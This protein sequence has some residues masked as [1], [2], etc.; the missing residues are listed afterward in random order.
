MNRTPLVLAVSFPLLG[1]IRNFHPLATCAA[2]RTQKEK[3]AFLRPFPIFT[4]PHKQP[5]QKH[6][7]CYIYM[8]GTLTNSKFF[9][10]LT[11]CRLVLNNIICDFYC[12]LLD[13]IFHILPLQLLLLQCMQRILLVCL[14]ISAFRLRS[15]IFPYASILKTFPHFV[16]FRS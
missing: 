13:I 1:R 5:S 12:S 2:R 4:S 6:V 7:F 3:A 15:I 10:G 11:H 16:S 8:Y 14:D 9:C